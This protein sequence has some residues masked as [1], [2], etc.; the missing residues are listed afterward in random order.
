MGWNVQVTN[1]YYTFKFGN[2]ALGS[3]MFSYLQVHVSFPALV[4]FNI[5]F[6]HRDKDL[7]FL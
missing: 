3:P 4:L 6:F 2:N 5:N 1:P 7:S